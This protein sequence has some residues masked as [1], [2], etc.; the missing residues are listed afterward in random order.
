MERLS[1]QVMKALA[2]TIDAKDKYTNGHSTR[3]AEYSREIARRSGRNEQEQEDIYYAGLLH[4]IGKIGIPEEIINKTSRL[5]DEEYEVIKTHPVIGGNILKNISEISDISLGAKWH[6]ER[7]DGRGYPDR[8]QGENI[9]E[10]ARIIGVADAYDAMTSKRSYRGVMPQEVVRAEIE[11]GKG[12]QF[13][14]RYADVM[15]AMI[16]GDTEYRMHE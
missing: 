6:H 2:A 3:V 9:P 11:K 8:L 15:L 13:D 16:D 12:S 4:D 7:Y 1:L 14:P 10:V 5:T